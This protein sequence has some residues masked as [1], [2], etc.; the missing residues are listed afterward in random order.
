MPLGATADDA[1]NDDD[2]ADDDD[3]D[4]YDNGR[5]NLQ[6]HSR[7]IKSYRHEKCELHTYVCIP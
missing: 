7:L 6:R 4:G 2:A 3:Y 1:N 5:P